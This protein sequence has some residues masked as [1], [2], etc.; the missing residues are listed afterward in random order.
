MSTINKVIL[1]GHVGKEP[2]FRRL[3]GKV[4]V[5]S[6]PLATS[7]RIKRDG[8]SMELTEWHNIVMWRATAE[9]ALKS[10]E[11][12]VIV[13]LEGSAKTRSFEDSAGNK[14]HITE[15][16]IDHFTVLGRP[17]DFMISD[18]AERVNAKP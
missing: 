13:Y 15:I 2:H 9:S 8:Q 11:K 7:E 6:F 14:K 16:I 10:L 17:S 1:V 3:D 12:G 18:K 5:I 4:P